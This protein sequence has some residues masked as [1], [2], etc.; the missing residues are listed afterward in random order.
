MILEKRRRH[1]A[2]YREIGAVL[3]KYGWTQLIARLGLAELFRTKPSAKAVE[4]PVRLREALEELGP[5]FI[6]LGQLLSSRPDIVPEVYIKELTKLQDTAPIVPTPDIIAIVEQEFGRQVREVYHYF[7]P[8]PVAAASLGQVHAAALHSGEE[9]IV[10]V[11]RPHI[12]GAID[13]DIEIMRGLA[14]FLE[15]RWETARLYGLTDL[16]D[17]YSIMIHEELDYTHEAHNTEK[18]RE[19]LIRNP[20]VTAPRV[21][22]DL[23]TPKVLTIERIR[24]DK[25]T[26]V[27]AL[28]EKGI[29]PKAVAHKLVSAFL[30][31]IFVDAFFHA[32]P[33]PGNIIVTSNGAIGLVD[34]GQA[35]RLDHTTKSGLLRLLIAFEQ[36]NARDFT[37]ELLSIGVAFG[38]VNVRE[39]T[40][41]ISKLLR[42]Y[43]DLPAR[44]TDLGGLLSRVLNVSAHHRVRFP[45]QFAI[46]AKVFALLQDVAKQLDPDFSFTD[47]AKP[48]I[49]R[50]V[51]TELTLEGLLTEFF[52]AVSDAKRLAFALPDRANELLR[53]L[54][55][56]TLKLEGRVLGLE[57]LTTKIDKLANRL[58]F[59]MICSGIVVASSIIVASGRG[60]D[61][62]FGLPTLGLIGYILAAIFGIWLLISIIRGGRL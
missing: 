47:A 33:H 41:D 48:Y 13:T 2:R 36:Q 51:R 34:C 62:L 61:G 44:E 18:L 16:I 14:A 24:G 27:H 23:T 54:V 43:Y 57:D 40:H 1:V 39:F 37:D 31:Q 20:D 32:D 38:P 46:L 42:R 30:Q 12:V 45:A 10:K 53:R 26:D 49:G 9:V 58:S 4:T 15:Q 19:K 35:A 59:A 52:Q 8:N 11:Q 17:E 25:V 60:R 56:G 3:A 50:A 29:D 7:D 28:R 21:Y 6:K 5:T 55:E 22:W